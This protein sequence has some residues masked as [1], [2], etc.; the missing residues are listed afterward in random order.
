MEPRLG[1]HLP[2]VLGSEYLM[3]PRRARSSDFLSDSRLVTHSELSLE[4]Q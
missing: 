1:L 2:V 4:N 3:V